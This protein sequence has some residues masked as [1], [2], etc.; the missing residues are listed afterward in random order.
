MLRSCTSTATCKLSSRMT[1]VSLFRAI[2]PLSAQIQAVG[3]TEQFVATDFSKNRRFVW[4]SF[5]IHFQ[6]VLARRGFCPL[7]VLFLAR[8]PTP[9][10]QRVF[11][12]ESTVERHSCYLAAMAEDSMFLAHLLLLRCQKTHKLIL[13]FLPLQAFGNV[14]PVRE[15]PVSSESERTKCGWTQLFG[16][17]R[18]IDS[19]N[20][21]MKIC[22]ITNYVDHLLHFKFSAVVL[23]LR[24]SQ[25]LEHHLPVT[26]SGNPKNLL[27]LFLN[28]EVTL[29]QKNNVEKYLLRL[30]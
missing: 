13:Y 25:Q 19:Q 5:C 14:E 16:S 11:L 12:T 26:V 3:R 10:V 8:V 18:R 21:T 4:K 7:T 22:K 6:G 2:S 27:R 1:N 29:A 28:L 30:F 15:N 23:L 17:P 9:Y 24:L 20:R